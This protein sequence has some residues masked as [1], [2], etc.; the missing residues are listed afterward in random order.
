MEY[1]KGGKDRECCSHGVRGGR[2]G[3]CDKEGIG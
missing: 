3:I 2:L 1:L